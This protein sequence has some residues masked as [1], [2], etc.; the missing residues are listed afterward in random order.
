MTR[1]GYSIVEAANWYSYV[2]N[3]P[4][5]YVDPTGEVA[6]SSLLAGIT[7]ATLAIISWIVVDEVANAAADIAEALSS[8]LPVLMSPPSDDT[9]DEA[10]QDGNQTSEENN[11]DNV[12]DGQAKTNQDKRHT[13]DQQ[14]LNELAKEGKRSG[15]TNSDADTLLEWDQE[16]GMGGRDDRGE[17]H[18]VGGEHIHAGG[19]DHIPVVE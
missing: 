6:I 16:V 7:Y 11:S 9:A 5:K 2:S 19:Q 8:A 12:S 14:A 15:V 13:P 18:W 10:D 17:D 3:N 4:V 1:S